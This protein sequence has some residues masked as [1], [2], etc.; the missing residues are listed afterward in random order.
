ME[1]KNCFI[2]KDCFLANNGMQDFSGWIG[3][4]IF[5]DFCFW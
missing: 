5:T 2:N 1:K 3:K 4:T